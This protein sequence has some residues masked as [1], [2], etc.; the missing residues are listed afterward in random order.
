MGVRA[1]TLAPLLAALAL[2]SAAAAAPARGAPLAGVKVASCQTGD[3]SSDRSA[4]FVGH[5]R[6]VEGSKQ[7]LMRF[8]LEEHYGRQGFTRVAAPDLRGWRKSRPGV[9][10]YSYSQGVT[11]LLAGESYR[12]Q[13]VFRWLDSDGKTILQVRRH[14]GVCDQPGQLP[15]LKVVDVTAR[16]GIVPGTEAYT[17]DVLNAGLVSA[18]HVALQIVIDGATPD[19]AT[20]DSLAPAELHAIHFTGPA[21][22]H[23]VRA[24]VDPSD[25]VHESIENDN[26]LAGGC[27]PLG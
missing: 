9:K 27:P 15:N 12:A 10:S 16:P 11:G 26:S 19:T 8:G 22:K 1:L 4:T 24:T 21:C 5:M 13:V 23:R 2:P 25:T 7:L 3:Q 20:V 18:S 6:A 14:S 17:V